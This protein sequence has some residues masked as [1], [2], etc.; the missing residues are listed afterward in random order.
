MEPKAVVVSGEAPESDDES[1]NQKI[2]PGFPTLLASNACGTIIQGE[3][4]E[5]DEE[6]NSIS[7]IASY[8]ID[9]T[10][11]S[12]TEAKGVRSEKSCVKYNSL[13]HKKL[14]ECNKIFDK[15]M[16]DFVSSTVTSAHEE[17]VEANKQLLK[18][19]FVLQEAMTKMQISCN[20]FEDVINSLMQIIEE[21]YFKSVKL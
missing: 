3:A 7:S 20:Q 2:T 4:Q 15:N 11:C 19:E 21:D 6:N 17:L 13:L 8:G 18:S 1:T 14:R 5:S 12:Y 10:N 9:P 16:R